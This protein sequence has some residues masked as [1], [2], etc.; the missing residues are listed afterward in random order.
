MNNGYIPKYTLLFE[1]KTNEDN[2]Y[3]SAKLYTSRKQ[4]ERDLTLLQTNLIYSKIS[5]IEVPSNWRAT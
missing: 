1:D 5:L 4:A 2:R 3:L